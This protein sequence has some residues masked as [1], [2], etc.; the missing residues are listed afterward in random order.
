MITTQH[1]EILSFVSKMTFL[2]GCG[3]SANLNLSSMHGNLYISFNVDLG[4]VQQPSAPHHPSHTPSPRCKPSQMRRRL[5]RRRAQ[6]HKKQYRD[7]LRTDEGQNLEVS[8]EVEEDLLGLDVEP[9]LTTS[10]Q[11]LA[12]ESMP[13]NNMYEKLDLNFS[14]P[15]L[16]EQTFIN[17]AH[18]ID[19]LDT[20]YN[21]NYDSATNST[22]PSNQ[23]VTQ[24]RNPSAN[25]N[26][27]AS[28]KYWEQMLLMAKYL[29][30]KSNHG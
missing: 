30:A 11:T 21:S 9:I 4:K 26:D 18:E 5:R 1:E 6:A 20:S 23:L 17:K 22:L 13:T 24:Q 15:V 7:D 19:T 3:I 27:D 14:E 10:D 8:A 2:S 28:T 25:P 29:T 12:V 16:L